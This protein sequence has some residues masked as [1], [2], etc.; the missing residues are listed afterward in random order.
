M[1]YRGV[2]QRGQGRGAELGFPTVNISLQAAGVSGIFAATVFIGDKQYPAAV[3][4]DPSR[5]VLEAHLLDFS[6]DLYDKE[7]EIE[8]LE[9]IRDDRKFSDEAGLKQAI[10]EDIAKV[11]EYRK[12]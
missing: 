2:V 10:A 8:L 1:R 4:A 9:K 3:Y 5:D 11:R 7:V 6:D 12:N